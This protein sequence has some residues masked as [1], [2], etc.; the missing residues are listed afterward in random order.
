MHSLSPAST[1]WFPRSSKLFCSSRNL[2]LPLAT[3]H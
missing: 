3:L 2:A 1:A